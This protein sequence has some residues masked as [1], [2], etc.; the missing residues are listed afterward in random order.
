MQEFAK[1]A[2][3]KKLLTTHSKRRSYSYYSFF[4]SFFFSRKT[5]SSMDSCR[6]SWDLESRFVTFWGPSGHLFLSGQRQKG[7]FTPFPPTLFLSPSS[8]RLR[9]RLIVKG[10]IYCRPNFHLKIHLSICDL[11]SADWN[12]EVEKE[13]FQKLKE[14]KKEEKEKEKR[15]KMKTTWGGSCW[16]HEIPG[17][18]LVKKADFSLDF[19]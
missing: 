17:F 14:K 2:D 11:W 3:V 7:S 15:G 5:S 12:E 8:C 10:E 9:G 16:W 19:H 18:L 13:K 4:L 1:V 6:F